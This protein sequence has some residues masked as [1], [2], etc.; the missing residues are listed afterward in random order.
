M[1]FTLTK[2]AVY[3]PVIYKVVAN[4]VHGLL[5]RT[6]SEEHLERK[7]QRE[8]ENKNKNKGTITTQST[9]RKTIEEGHCKEVQRSTCHIM[10][11]ARYSDL[12]SSKLP[13]SRL[14]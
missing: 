7:L 2:R 14:S 11:T 3:Y 12:F 9:C 4:P 10:A 8:H 13:N 6:G 5:D 1:F